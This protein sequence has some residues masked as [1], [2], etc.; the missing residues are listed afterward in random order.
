[1]GKGL[2]HA[3]FCSKTKSFLALNSNQVLL[4]YLYYQAYL[5]DKQAQDA[6]LKLGMNVLLLDPI[7]HIKATAA[8]DNEAFSAQ[9]PLIVKLRKKKTL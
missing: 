1:M 5:G 4:L 8:G 3:V 6:V 2:G 9:I 7:P